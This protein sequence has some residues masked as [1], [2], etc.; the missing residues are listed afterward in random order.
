MFQNVVVGED[1]LVLLLMVLLLLLL[2]LLL[3][4]DVHYNRQVEGEYDVGQ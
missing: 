2:L 3:E 1:L 4:M